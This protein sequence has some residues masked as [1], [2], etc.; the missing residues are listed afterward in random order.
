MIAVR[1]SSTSGVS[2]NATDAAEHSFAVLSHHSSSCCGGKCSLRKSK[3]HL[4]AFWWSFAYSS[5]VILCHLLVVLP[6]GT[7]LLCLC[8]YY[9][10]I[11]SF[12]K[13]KKMLRFILPVRSVL[14]AQAYAS[15]PSSLFPQGTLRIYSHYITCCRRS[16]S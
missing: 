11:C 12:C 9:T 16:M 8:S 1:S 3:A 2:P 13:L 10:H 7:S 6:Y 5:G 14:R 4:N 15:Y